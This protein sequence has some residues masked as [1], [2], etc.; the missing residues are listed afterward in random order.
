MKVCYI[1]VKF[2]D[3]C[4]MVQIEDAMTVNILGEGLFFA[5]QNGSYK[6]PSQRIIEI[7]FITKIFPK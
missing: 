3:E 4:G 5:N 2:E 7:N 6:I 1:E